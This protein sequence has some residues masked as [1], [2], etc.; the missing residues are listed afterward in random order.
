MWRECKGFIA[1]LA[2]TLLC[3]CLVIIGM[4][5][6]KEANPTIDLPPMHPKVQP[7]TK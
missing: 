1:V 2:I 7:E 4:F 3:A 6:H 5:I